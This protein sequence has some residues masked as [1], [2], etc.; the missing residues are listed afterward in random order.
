MGL[1]SVVYGIYIYVCVCKP[2][3]CGLAGCLSMIASTHVIVGVLYACVNLYFEV[4]FVQ[5]S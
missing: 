3:F 5:T 4:V 1:Y 2:N